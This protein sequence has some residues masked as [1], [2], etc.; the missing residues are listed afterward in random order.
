MLRF[1]IYS[2]S[3]NG[4]IYIGGD[5]VIYLRRPH[6]IRIGFNVKIKTFEQHF[7]I[8]LTW[9]KTLCYNKEIQLKWSEF[10]SRQGQI[11]IRIP[12]DTLLTINSVTPSIDIV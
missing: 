11:Q 6:A 1:S 9:S 10:E 12:R 8:R 7:P 5:L 4:A 3:H 2:S